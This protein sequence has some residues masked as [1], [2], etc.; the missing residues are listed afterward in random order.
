MFKRIKRTFDESRRWAPIAFIINVIRCT[1]GAHE[2][3]VTRPVY[4]NIGERYRYRW[5]RERQHNDSLGPFPDCSPFR[6][7]RWTNPQTIKQ[8]SYRIEEKEFCEMGN[9]F[10]N[11]LWKIMGPK[12]RISCFT[13][14]KHR[15]QLLARKFRDPILFTFASYFFVF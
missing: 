12:E 10:L 3:V 1:W 6:T 8:E 11:N 13:G 14:T 15:A 4:T 9:N 2:H 7:K 5:E